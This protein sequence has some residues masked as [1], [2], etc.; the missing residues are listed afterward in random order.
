MADMK[1]T[2]DKQIE[3]TQSTIRLAADTVGKF[4]DELKATKEKVN[5]TINSIEAPF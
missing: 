1:A 4:S 2:F 5:E 3:K